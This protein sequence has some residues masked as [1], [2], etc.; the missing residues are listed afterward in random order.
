M[1]GSAIQKTLF[2]QLFFSST[3]KYV[4]YFK[5]CELWHHLIVCIGQM[6]SVMLMSSWR[7]KTYIKSFCKIGILMNFACKV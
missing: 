1:D 3:I 7:V 2:I 6:E 4:F 5:R